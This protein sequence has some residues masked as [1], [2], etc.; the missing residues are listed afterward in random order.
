[1]AD[2]KTQAAVAIQAGREVFAAADRAADEFKK[3]AWE[4]DGS[5][6]E[7]LPA[8][9]SGCRDEAEYLSLCFV[10][11]EAGISIVERVFA[12]SI[13]GQFEGALKAMQK[14]PL[15]ALAA[16]RDA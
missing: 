13:L 5:T 8:L 11:D 15:A 9:R 7:Y 6:N 3:L 10:G 1:M 12:A 4:L 16:S 2:V 14:A